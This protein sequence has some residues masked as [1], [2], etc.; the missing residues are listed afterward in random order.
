M[1]K[2]EKFIELVKFLMEDSNFRDL[3]DDEKKEIWGDAL[4]YWNALQISEENTKIKFTENGKKILAYMKENKDNHSNLF[5]AKEIG[6][7]LGITSRTA[8]GALRKLVN[9]RYVEKVGEN[10]VIYS[11]TSTGVDYEIVAED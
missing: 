5:K 4:D 1:S 7:G 6:E 9:D 2:K 8:S 3:D 10:P 11:L